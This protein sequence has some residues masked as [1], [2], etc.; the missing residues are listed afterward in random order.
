MDSL[1]KALSETAK[2]RMTFVDT[3]A[4]AKALEARHLS[5]PTAGKVLAESLVAVALLSGDAASEE[6]A[7]LMRLSASGPVRG[8]V[9]EALGDGGLRGYTLVKILNDLDGR[10]TIDATAALGKLGSA[11]V[12]KTL[13]GKILN[14]A[15]VKTGTPSPQIVVAKYF[16]LSMQ[17]PTGAAIVVDTTANGLLH[18][19]GLVAQRMPDG[20]SE[21]FVRVLQRFDDGSVARA[22]SGDVPPELMGEVLGLGDAAVREGRPLAFRCRCSRERAAASFTALSKEELESMIAEA[23]PQNVTCHMCGK[24]YVFESAELREILEHRDASSHS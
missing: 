3:T 12:T 21:L 14:E 9:V 23:S 6:E 24:D 22:L 11:V 17:V 2:V 10:E 5:G 18:A 20:E 7:V 4:A 15:S 8:C 1:V 19:R 13:P 16:N